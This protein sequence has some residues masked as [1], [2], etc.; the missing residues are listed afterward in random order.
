MVDPPVRRMIPYAGHGHGLPQDVE[1]A[2]RVDV[3]L[4]VAVWAYDLAR[5]ILQM[6][7]AGRSVRSEI[8]RRIFCSRPGSG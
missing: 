4:L 8:V 6:G 3:G 2:G 5:R 1:D 7:L